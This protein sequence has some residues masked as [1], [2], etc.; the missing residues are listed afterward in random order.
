MER[1]EMETLLQAIKRVERKLD[2]V[3]RAIYEHDE[4]IHDEYGRSQRTIEAGRSRDAKGDAGEILGDSNESSS[5]EPRAPV[6]N[7]RSERE[8]NPARDNGKVQ[9]E[10]SIPR[11]NQKN[12]NIPRENANGGASKPNAT[13][14][15]PKR[16]RGKR[17]SNEEA[18]GSNQGHNL[19]KVSD[20]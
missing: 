18:R 3:I 16:R 20:V 9:R 5:D 19:G 17:G 7:R 6:A 13:G 11:S 14:R 1:S 12:Q 10:G 2:T 15:H 8:A 4:D